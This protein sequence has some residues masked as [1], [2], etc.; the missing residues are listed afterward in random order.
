EDVT[1]NGLSSPAAVF[2]PTSPSVDG[3]DPRPRRRP[4]ASS[5]GFNPPR[6]RWTARTERSAA[7]AKPSEVSTHL[8]VGGR[9]GPG[10]PASSLVQERAFQPTSPS[11]DG[12]DLGVYLRNGGL[13]WMF[14]P[15]S[16]SVDG[17]DWRCQ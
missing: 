16:P 11:V 14:Q 7:P 5:C 4:R 17:E 12:E 6:R 8:A 3:E 13:A 10:H 2:Q 15:T 9:R 1:V